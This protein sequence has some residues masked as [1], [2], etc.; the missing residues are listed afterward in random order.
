MRS[1][2]ASGVFTL[3]THTTHQPHLSLLVNFEGSRRESWRDLAL[4]IASLRGR[5]PAWKNRRKNMEKTTAED[6][7]SYGNT[8]PPL[9]QLSLAYFAASHC[10]KLQH[11]HD[12]S[13]L[14]FTRVCWGGEAILGQFMVWHAPLLFEVWRFWWRERIGVVELSSGDDVQSTPREKERERE[15]SSLN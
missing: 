4:I 15:Y 8:P 6:H 1:W 13:W 7:L 11:I 2:C 10:V 9:P 5:L 3:P 14:L 12:F